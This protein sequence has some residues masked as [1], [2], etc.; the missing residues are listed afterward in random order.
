MI[1]QSIILFS[2]LL[3]LFA[4]LL[5]SPSNKL[6]VSA[7]FAYFFI[8]WYLTNKFY[9]SLLVTFLT[10]SIIFT[11]KTHIVQLL[12]LSEYPHLQRIYPMG[13]V[14][15]V[16]IRTMDIV[17]FILGVVALG[18]IA[19]RG[20]TAF[21]TLFDA[22]IVGFCIWIVLS[23]LFA[24]TQLM[25]SLYQTSSII[26]SICLHIFLTL[27]FTRKSQLPTIAYTLL[28]LV[29]FEV[30]L[31]MFQFITGSPLGKSIEIEQSIPK[32]GGVVDE[33]YFTFRPI[34]TFIHPNNYA[35]YLSIISIVCFGLH[36]F[37]RKAI[38]IQT[39]LASFITI[40]LTLSRTAWFLTFVSC[41]VYLYQLEHVYRIN[42]L[43]R[44]RKYIWLTIILIPLTVYMMPR[45]SKTIY[46]FQE[47]GGGYYRLHQSIEILE[48]IK[49]NPIFGVGTGLSVIE[50]IRS[51][52]EGFFASSPDLIHNYYLLVTAESGIISVIL[53]ILMAFSFLRY[54]PILANSQ[55][56]NNIL[57]SALTLAGCIIL[58]A[59]FSQPFMYLDLLVVLYHMRRLI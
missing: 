12:D 10:S 54:K 29:L 50:S 3:L 57:Y 14:S 48:L 27:F 25:L 46:T 47:S 30:V 37:Y 17:A 38:F 44:V 1:R 31:S 49:K 13:Y 26:E 55:P 43:P 6:V 15:V 56:R 32:F 45:I 51:N 2:P 59:P 33:F 35:I 16:V 58:L 40:G 23:N 21:H 22:S 7:F 39:A 11:G 52:P 24:S 20:L 42:L 8:R 36:W 18:K 9:E 19:K 34:G 4:L 5:I 53:L 28:S 41:C